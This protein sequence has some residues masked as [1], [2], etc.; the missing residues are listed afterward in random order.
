MNSFNEYEIVFRASVAINKGEKPE[1][2]SLINALTKR[3]ETAGHEKFLVGATSI[4]AKTV[5][6]LGEEDVAA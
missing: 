5:G 2:G 1:L 3:L 6:D 4:S